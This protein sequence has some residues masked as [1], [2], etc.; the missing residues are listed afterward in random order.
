MVNCVVDSD[1]APNSKVDVAFQQK[2]QTC[3]F[4][5]VLCEKFT[6]LAHIGVAR[7]NAAQKSFPE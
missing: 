3:C 6:K 2:A 5:I 4:N 1:K 7:V